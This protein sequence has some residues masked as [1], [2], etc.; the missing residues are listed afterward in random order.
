MVRYFTAEEV[1]RHNCREDCWVSIYD[2]VFDITPLVVQGPGELSAPLLKAAGTS[3]SHWFSKEDGD[4]KTFI[5][6]EKNIRLP[7]TPAG[8]FIDVPPPDPRVLNVNKDRPWWLD[9]KYIVGKV[10]SLKYLKS[11]NK[12]LVNNENTICEDCE[13]ADSHSRCH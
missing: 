13:Y 4:L 11:L 9:S 7:F 8:R 10:M 6:P 2:N 1:A 5:D 12:S 3:I